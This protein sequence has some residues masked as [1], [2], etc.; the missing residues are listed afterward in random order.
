MSEEPPGSG[1]RPESRR[2]GGGW[3]GAITTAGVIAG[4]VALLA[5]ILRRRLPPPETGSDAGDGEPAPAP[6]AVPGAAPAPAAGG[7]SVELLDLWV[8]GGEL[9][10]T[11]AN[12]G[13]QALRAV[14]WTMRLVPGYDAE[15]DF[16]GDDPPVIEVTGGHDSAIAAGGSAVVT[17]GEPPGW[18]LEVRVHPMQLHAR[19]ELVEAGGVRS[20]SEQRGRLVLFHVRS[21]QELE[22]IRR[23]Y[24][25]QPGSGEGRPPGAPPGGA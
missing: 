13:G 25:P 20:E 1:W 16:G 7:A 10:G 23:A 24:A 15:N 3:T 8:L 6:G 14:S 22:E 11:L 18:Y 19:Y 21:E 2:P 5:W 4:A 9:R 12:T 17:L